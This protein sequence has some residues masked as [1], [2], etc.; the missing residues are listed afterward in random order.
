M[1][2]SL[3]AY[4]FTLVLYIV[5]SF[6]PEYRV[7]GFN[8]WAYYPFWAKVLLVAIGALAPVPILRL[9]DTP[10][11][12]ESA[13]RRYALIL[14]SAVLAFGLLTLFL[15]SHMH[16]LG[17][18]FLQLSLLEQGKTT[19]RLWDVFGGWIRGGLFSV[20]SGTPAERALVAYQATSITAGLITLVVFGLI[21]G[22]TYPDRV[23]RLLLF[24]LL[25][26]AG[27]ALLFF[28]Y[29]ENY[30]PFVMS[31]AIF[32]WVQ[33][34]VCKGRIR[35]WWL[36]P[37][38]LFVLV[39]HIFGVAVLPVVGYTI[40]DHYLAGRNKKLQTVIRRWLP[41][42]LVLAMAL[43]AVVVASRSLFV[44]F[45]LV[46]FTASEVTVGGYTMFSPAHLG[47]LLNLAFV[48]VP[49]LAVMVVTFLGKSK[50]QSGDLS[51]YLWLLVIPS[52]FIA[53]VFNP[54]LGMARDWD[55]FAFVGVPTAML[56][57]VEL[58]DRHYSRGAALAVVLG[59]LVLL[60]RAISQ[61]IPEVAIAHFRADA[62]REPVQSRGGRSFLLA[63]YKNLS[64]TAKARVEEETFYRDY[65][66][67]TIRADA[68]RALDQNRPVDALAFA[69]QLL[70]IDPRFFD[71]YI[72][73]AKA[74]M[75]MGN[76][77][78]AEHNVRIADALNPN[79]AYALQL[80]G[81]LLCARGELDTGLR[82]F[83]R[84]RAI[85]DSLGMI[86]GEITL[87]LLAHGDMPKALTEIQRLL[88][89]PTVPARLFGSVT[90]ALLDQGNVEEAR[91]AWLEA[92]RRG[93]DSL[94]AADWMAQDP[95]L[96]SLSESK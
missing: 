68:R 65:P 5:F 33:I 40:F 79:N 50:R 71:A 48:L 54:N 26:T 80:T 8:W 90:V 96:R 74:Y 36:L 43:G 19:G 52:W 67:Q 38:A 4:Y 94:A 24:A 56:L 42:A 25:S 92:G 37:A 93:M 69:R 16:L 13:D 81:R 12:E 76:A 41:W 82:T 73:N 11:A 44:K 61:A 63:Y 32:L 87:T 95:R 72:V 58:L 88:D 47:D 21:A 75:Q 3:I 60:P 62:K 45:S 14:G 10:R 20:L 85:N 64:D 83:Y 53:I 51:F 89:D 30:A 2:P 7:W 18:G 70:R 91:K 59:L 31:L 17:D 9:S 6:L 29:V 22:A 49:G 39:W 34:L 1:T 57:A 27:Y 35:W 84:A 66:V 28:G 23:R 77:D 15:R 46:P 78:A 55:L 86:T